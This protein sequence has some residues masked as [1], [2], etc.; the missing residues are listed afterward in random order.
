MVFVFLCFFSCFFSPR[1]KA[2]IFMYIDQNNNNNQKS[3]V[4]IWSVAS[5]RLVGGVPTSGS[6]FS[7]HSRYS[8]RIL[9]C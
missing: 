8:S 6:L 1:M 5:K 4:S 3:L 7:L 9:Y 2:N